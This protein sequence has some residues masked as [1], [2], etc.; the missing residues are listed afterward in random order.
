MP[1][2]AVSGRSGRWKGTCLLRSSIVALLATAPLVFAQQPASLVASYQFQNTLSPQRGTLPLIPVDPQGRNAFVM[3]TVLGQSRLVYEWGGAASPN[4]QQ[5]GLIFSGRDQFSRTNYSVELI[6]NFASGSGFRRIVD[7]TNRTEER[8]LYADASN[9]LT[10]YPTFTASTGQL[11]PGAYRH[12]VFSVASSQIILYVD[13]AEV[14]RSSTAFLGANVLESN[15]PEQLIHLFLDNT[16]GTSNEWSAGRIALFRVYTGGLSAAEVAELFRSPFN[17]TVGLTAPTFSSN[18]VV[19]AAS[20]SSTNPITPGAFFSI[21]GTNLA[22]Q[23]GDW[24]NDFSNNTAPRRLNGVRVL[25]QDQEASLSFTRGDQINAIAPET[26]PEGPVTVVVENNGLRSNPV[27]VQSR[28]VNPALFRFSPNNFRYAASTANDGSAYIA[29]RNLFDSSE[30]LNGLPVRPARPG[31]FVV[32]Y[33]TGLG[34]TNPPLPAGQIPPPREGGYPTAN[35]VTLQF[36]GTGGSPTRSVVPAYA[37]LSGF[38][39]LV[40]IVFQAP[41]LPDG[42]YEVVLTLAGVT[43]P[44]GVW[45]PIRR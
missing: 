6:F 37:G 29:P 22:D 19:H 8:G 23:G 15:N 20:F 32:I 33:G 31:E 27:I 36:T 7:V 43:S 38:P 21:F 5:G 25:V 40:Q 13:G 35:I 30:V 42:E 2:L 34:A 9:R 18:N 1:A 24:S 39:G 3:D 14:G 28:R 17:A 10:W 16:S 12:V 41:D 11:T 44:G 4:S 26:V 45:L